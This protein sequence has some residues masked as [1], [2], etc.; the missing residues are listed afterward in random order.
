SSPDDRLLW[1]VGHQSY[2]HK[3]LTGRKDRFDRLRKQD[4][5]SG[6]PKQHESIH[7]AFLSGHS[8]NTVSAA[9]GIA[10]ALKLSGSDHHAITVIG[11]GSF[12]GGMVYEALDNA[13]QSDA[14]IIVILNHNNMSISKNVGSFAQY[15]S[16]V[17][18]K[19]GYHRFKKLV[20]RT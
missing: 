8:S 11:D 10:E 5:L 19:R 13:G 4:G 18:S 16:Q 2:T 12:T 1:D 20:H 14:N 7:D 6:F 17:R 9:F 3:I 15:L